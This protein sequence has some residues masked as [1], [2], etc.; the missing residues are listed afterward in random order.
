VLICGLVFFGGKRMSIRKKLKK[1]APFVLVFAVGLLFGTTYERLNFNYKAYQ[2][3]FEMIDRN[4]I[5]SDVNNR[6]EKKIESLKKELLLEQEKQNLHLHTS[7]E[8]IDQKKAIEK[9]LKELK[10]TE[11]IG[12]GTG[13]PAF[14][15]TD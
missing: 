11:N 4:H 6:L 8:L 7:Q 1:F 10:E 2:G 13:S 9:R 12:T 3:V 14:L 5:E 15:T